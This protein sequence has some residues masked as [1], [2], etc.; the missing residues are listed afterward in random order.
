[1]TSMRRIRRLSVAAT[2]PAGERADGHADG[3]DHDL[4][5]DRDRHADPRAVE[6]AA[7]QVAPDLVRP[8][9]VSGAPGRQ[10]LAAILPAPP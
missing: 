7:E 9:D 4:D 10:R 3:E 8:Q 5:D 1:M 6:Q 2:E